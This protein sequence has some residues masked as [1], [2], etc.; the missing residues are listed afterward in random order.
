[1]DKQAH[2]SQWWQPSKFEDKLPFL[3]NRARIIKNVRKFFDDDGFL[4]VETPCVV[5]CPTMDAH[6]HGFEVTGAGFLHASPEF[7]MKKLL[8]AGC[9]KIYQICPVFRKE[10]VG[11]LH[12][13][14]FTMI[15]WYRTNAD[16]FDLMNDCQNLIQNISGNYSHKDKKCNSNLK[17]E[18]ITVS[19]AFEKYANL[20]LDDYL[21]DT[22][23]FAKD[24]GVKTSKDDTWDDIFH[25][26]MAQKIEPFLGSPAPTILHDYPK[27]MAS[28]AR[29]NDKGFAQRM[30]L[31]ICGI[32]LANGFSELTDA[33]VQRA[34]FKK[35]RAQKQ[36]IYGFSYAPDEDFLNAL[37]LG[38]PKSAGIAL[39]IDSLVMLVGDARD[40]NQVK[41][42]E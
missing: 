26:I 6:I 25:T 8:V 3:K 18:I 35:D 7:E 13:T 15:E 16:Y 12:S 20:C 2:T 38:M 28:L 21:D 32:E 9:E 1:M 11:K 19:D 4:A 29:L 33:D 5:P 27:S 34:R 41:W 42:C 24:C 31:Y 40:I 30:E 23:R 37:E 14:E 36:E 22:P 17:W 39:G 10:V